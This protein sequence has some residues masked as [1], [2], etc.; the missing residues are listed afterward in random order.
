MIGDI[1][2]KTITSGTRMILMTF[3]LAIT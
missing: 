3:R 1:T 2:T